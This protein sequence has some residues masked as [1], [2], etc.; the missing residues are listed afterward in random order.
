M[1]KSILQTWKCSIRGTLLCQVSSVQLI[2]SN[3]KYKFELFIPASTFHVSLAT[4]RHCWRVGGSNCRAILWT[5]NVPAK[6]PY[7]YLFYSLR[8]LI[9]RVLPAHSLLAPTVNRQ[10]KHSGDHNFVH[11]GK[12]VTQ[13]LTRTQHLRSRLFLVICNILGDLVIMNIHHK[14]SPYFAETPMCIQN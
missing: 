8:T 4:A 12:V 2:W 7:L 5:K 1:Y 11:M 13:H 10:S 9:T 14:K 3:N 6:L